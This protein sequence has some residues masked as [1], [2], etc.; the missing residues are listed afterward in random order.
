MSPVELAQSRKPRTDI[1]SE[2]R[3]TVGGRLG[4]VGM[5]GIEM[6]IQITGPDGQTVLTPA[7]VDAFVNLRDPE[8]KGIHMSRLY[9]AVQQALVHSNTFA[10]IA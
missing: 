9:L 5:G 4:Q 6:P 7:I 8:A 10:S 3:A 1:A 2:S